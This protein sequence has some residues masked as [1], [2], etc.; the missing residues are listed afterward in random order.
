MPKPP[1]MEINLKAN[2]TDSNETQNE[3]RTINQE[4]LNKTEQTSNNSTEEPIKN[5]EL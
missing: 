1:K 3:N 5:E 4:T 2:G